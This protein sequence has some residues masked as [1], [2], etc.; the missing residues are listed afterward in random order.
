VHGAWKQR[1]KMINV[2]VVQWNY[3][4]VGIDEIR[5]L[6]MGYQ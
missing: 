6:M 5:C 2:G 4:P 1:E 3:E